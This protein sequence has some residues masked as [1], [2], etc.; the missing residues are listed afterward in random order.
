MHART[1]AHAHTHTQAAEDQG[2]AWPGDAMPHPAHHLLPRALWQGV[3]ARMQGGSTPVHAFYCALQFWA[4]VRAGHQTA[5]AS[6][7]GDYSCG[8][9][10]C[11]A[12][13]LVTAFRVACLLCKGLAGERPC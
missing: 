8:K 5:H 4:S 6:S 9:T 2:A 13:Y 1:H 10:E 11:S 12:D 7:D 3:C